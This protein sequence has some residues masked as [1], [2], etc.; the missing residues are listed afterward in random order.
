MG[1]AM[2]ASG[3]EVARE[4]ADMILMDDHFATIV[5][6]IEEG[7]T[8]FDNIRKFLNY[9]LTH[10]TPEIV[11]FAAFALLNIPLAITVILILSIDLFTEMLPAIALGSEKPESDVMKQKPIK[12]TEHILTRN[13]LIH[14]YLLIG[15]VETFAGFFAFFG[16]LFSH[17]WRWGIELGNNDP[18]YQKAVTAFF[19]A[20][21]VCQIANVFVSRTRRQSLFRTGLFTNKFLWLG[22]LVEVVFLEIIVYLPQTH[23]F[24]GTQPLSGLELMLGLPFA[25]FIFFFDEIRKL[26]LRKKVAIAERYFAW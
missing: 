1:V 26:L 12:R 23:V 20:V 4:A 25:I 24:F 9:I 21:I 5:N 18:I 6:A 2:G 15:V 3:T 19:A 13:L 8:I 7:R 22:V 11:P 16:V 17:G 14:S 10:L